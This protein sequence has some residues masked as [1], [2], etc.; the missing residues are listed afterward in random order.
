MAGLDFLESLFDRKLV[1]ILRVFFQFEEKKFYLKEISDAA[2][3]SMATT[4]RIL[5]RLVK[6][7]ILSEIKISK[8]KVYQLA[9]NEKTEF[10][11]SFIKGSVKVLDIFVDMIKDDD[12]IE[13]VILVGRESDAK[14]NIIVIGQNIDSEKI[15]LASSEIKDQYNY[16]ITYITMPMEQY[17]QMSSMGLYPGTKKTIYQKQ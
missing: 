8:F 15:K 5:T 7:G 4:H 2:K 14:A 6:I 3:V 12:A 11:S 1:S 16:K 13:A 17:D 9:K 10:L